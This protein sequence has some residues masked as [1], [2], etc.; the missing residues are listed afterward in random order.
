MCERGGVCLGAVG[1][2]DAVAAG[3]GEEGVDVEEVVV[4]VVLLVEG[5]GTP[6]VVEVAGEAEG[7]CRPEQ[8]L[9]AR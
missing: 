5:S 2:R 6:V 1:G 4:V 7:R 8:L 9:K 3:G